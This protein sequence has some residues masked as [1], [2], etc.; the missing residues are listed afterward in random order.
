VNTEVTN[1]PRDIPEWQRWNDYGIGML[2]KGKAE[3]RQAMEAFRRV[4]EL[5]RFDGPLNLA[6]TLV[7]EAGP[8]QLDEAAAALQR[9]A[10]HT[11][12]PAWPWTVRWLSGV[13]NRQQGRLAEAEENFRQV[14]EFRT[15]DTVK[16]GF[17]FS[18]DYMVI[19][20]LGQTIFDRALQIRGTDPAAVEKRKKRLI[21]AAEVF[22]KT[23]DIDSENVDAHY[24][25]SQLHAQLG[26]EEL[27]AHHK[28]EHEKYRVDDTAR[29][30][31]VTIARK[32]YPAADFA[33]EPLVIYD[34]QR[35]AGA[36]ASAAGESGDAA[37]ED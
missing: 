17:D 36:A 33:A 28:A 9:A 16:R 21:E 5:G 19:N 22:R 7:E 35:L 25:L 8:G 24:N 2:L 10:A 18:R 13:I 27:A 14:L 37:G 1:P 3:L 34:L 30:E 31:A 26:N 32:K 4:E 11:D 6:R 12:P 15:E 20:L 23:L 29:G